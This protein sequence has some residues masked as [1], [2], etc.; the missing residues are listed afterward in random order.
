[1]INALLGRRYLKEGVVPTTN[2]ITFLRYSEFNHDEKQHSERHPDGQFICYLP[3]PILKKMIIVDTPGT[4]VILQRQQRLTEEFLPRADLLLFVISSDR[5]LT[6]SEVAFL[7]YTQQW[8][9]KVVFV[10]N[11]IDLYRSANELE[12]AIAFIK[13]NTRKLLNTEKVILYPVSARSALEAKLSPSSDLEKD[14]KELAATPAQVKASGFLEL[15]KFLYSF[16]DGS[17]GTGLE[18]RKLKLETP[19]RIAERLLSSSE[20]FVRQE[21]QYAKKD[22]NAVNELVNSVNMYALKMESESISWKRRIL[23]LI[24]TTKARAVKLIQS[25]LKLTNF[26]VVSRYVLKGDSSAS[27][28]A[29]STIRNDI[30]GPALSDAQ[31]LLEDYKMWLQSN[32]ASERRLYEESFEKR[33]PSFVFSCNHSQMETYEPLTKANE[34]NVKVL[35]KFSPNVASNLFEEEIREV[36]LGTFG[37]IGAAGVSA[38]LLT[39]VLPTTIED[40]LALALCSAGG[41]LAISNF[42]A[43]RQ[44]VVDKVSR[45]ADVLAREIEEAMEKDLTDNIKNLENFVT[46]MGKPYKDAA[47]DR[48]DKSMQ[49]QDE[50]TNIEKKLQTLQIEIQGFD[51][52]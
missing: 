46:L 35:Q 42:P 51:V 48:L 50:L 19:V 27:M 17:T 24:D 9:K 1:M 13:E 32:I 15:E 33:W 22:I 16:L 6:E 30:V 39:T 23:S 45:I 52:S 26:D 2:E 40:L 38:S 28:P 34:V 7:R 29:A 41:L 25:T 3:A 10:L 20:A 18:R 14:Y 36:F 8:K 11:K 5:P 21:L 44:Q 4:N 12:E 49:I 37:G 43:R 31:T 47:Q